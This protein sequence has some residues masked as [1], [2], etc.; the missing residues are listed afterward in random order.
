MAT[1]AG[2]RYGTDLSHEQWAAIEMFL[3]PPRDRSRGGRP[4]DHSRRTL[5]NAVLYLVRT[6]VQWRY[7]PVEF[8]PWSTVWSQ[9]RRWRR[10]GSWRRAMVHLVRGCRVAVHRDPDPSV[11]L[12]DAQTVV[13]GRIG[14]REQVGTDGGKRI[15]GRKRHLLC[16]IDGL[17]IAIDVTSA[18]PHDSR[19]GWTLL[20]DA[21][22]QLTRLTKVFA[23]AAY[24]S[25]VARAGE[26]LDVTIDIRKRPAGTRGFV[27]LQPLWRV[28]RSFGWLS[29]CRRLRHDYEGTVASAQ[30]FAQVA[31]VAL[32]LNRLH[33]TA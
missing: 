15:T 8:P 29:R 30:T 32:L 31:A 27:P 10:S 16:D 9:F 24:T 22:P 13:S 25:L 14:P 28:E 33:P 11:A 26:E 5:A 4:P 7:L 18:R 19:G 12:L 23:D 6:G 21:R 2:Q 20:E 17:P 1:G 3:D